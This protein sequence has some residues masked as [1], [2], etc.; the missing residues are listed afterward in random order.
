M[1]IIIKNF[2]LK[3]FLI[4]VVAFAFLLISFSI[5]VLT[6]KIHE[7]NSSYTYLMGVSLLFISGFT[8][9]NYFQKQGFLLGCIQG[10]CCCFIFYLINILGFES[11]MTFG[12]FIKLL[13]YFTSGVLGGV[14]GVNVKKFI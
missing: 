11:G 3:Y 8:I 6:N 2:I 5:L 9:S 14:V 12:L 7:Q 10:F 1:V 13:I 4:L